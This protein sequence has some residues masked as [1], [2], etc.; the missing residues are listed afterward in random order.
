MWEVWFP[1]K[2]TD[3]VNASTLNDAV[4]IATAKSL[5]DGTDNRI[6][7]VKDDKGNI[8]TDIAITVSH[9]QTDAAA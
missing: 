5:H 8:F 2:R 6:V 9:K 1:K 7:S 4:I 3:Y